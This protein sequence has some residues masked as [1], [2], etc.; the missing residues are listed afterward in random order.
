MSSVDESLH[1]FPDVFCELY[2]GIDTQR[3]RESIESWLADTDLLSV[4]T[5]VA[6]DVEYA[7]T[8]PER[9][10]MRVNNSGDPEKHRFACLRGLDRAFAQVNPALRASRPV[11]EGLQA[12]ALHVAATQRL[13]SGKNG[14]ALLPRLVA[15]VHQ[16]ALPEHPR[17]LFA[18][19]IRVPP[20]AW[21]ACS[22]QVLGEAAALH[23]HEIIAGLSVACVPFI[24]DPDEL[25]FDVEQRE[26]GRF[27]R[28]A[29]RGLAVTRGRISAALEAL[30]SGGAMIGLVPELTLSAE[31]LADW[32]E[33]LRSTGR[34]ASRLHWL[35]VGS[36]DLNG[37]RPPRNTAV[38]LNAR[39]GDV[40]ASQD[41]LHRFSLSAEEIERWRLTELLGGEPVDEDLTPGQQLAVLDAGGVR[42]AVMVC[43]DLGRVVDLAGHV[44]DFGVSH[45][46]VPVFGRPTRDRR[47]ERAAAN[48]HAQATGSTI[49]VANSLVMASILDGA[50]VPDA[51][52]ETDADAG[53]TGLVVWP[54]AGDALVL[55]APS[56]ESAACFRLLADGTAAPS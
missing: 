24:A 7:R 42:V 22:Y 28:I 38:L 19:V 50:A 54:G 21:E 10:R 12:L 34:G 14:G 51:D 17:D 43:E 40:I 13:D 1:G 8:V 52:A 16:P 55:R 25:A 33:A 36:G 35:L 9:I 26:A 39:S 5:A 41:K 27:Y 11:P 56:P 48:V 37:E 4:T 18:S 47:W 30:D 53:G 23:R 20:A 29:P 2:D 3:F 49:V 46:L 6:G 45:L 32:Q 44:R 15:R 31:I